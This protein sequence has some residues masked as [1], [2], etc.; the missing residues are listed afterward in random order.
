MNLH[1]TFVYI[2]KM[3]IFSTLCANSSWGSG[4]TDACIFWTSLQS[5]DMFKV[6]LSEL[7]HSLI[8]MKWGWTLWMILYFMVSGKTLNILICVCVCDREPKLSLKIQRNS[9]IVP[10]STVCLTIS[11]SLN[12]CSQVIQI[13]FSNLIFRAQCLHY[14]PVFRFQS[15]DFNH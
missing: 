8:L 2:L 13:Y 9:C 11:S 5:R 7:H 1:V 3:S 15:V 6:L 14:L 10:F 12:T 4:A